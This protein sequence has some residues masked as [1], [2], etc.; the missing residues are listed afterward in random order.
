MKSCY[1]FI[2]TEVVRKVEAKSTGY[3]EEVRPRLLKRGGE[4][5]GEVGQ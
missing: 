5:G 2:E 4:V 1:L 3:V